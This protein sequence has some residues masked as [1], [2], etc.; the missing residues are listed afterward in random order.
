MWVW[1]GQIL[2]QTRTE[3]LD[4]VLRTYQAAGLFNGT[5]LVQH[6]GEVLLQQGYGYRDLDPYT[7]NLSQTQFQIG[8]LTKQFTA[9]IILRLQEQG[10]LRVSDPL[11]RFLP[12]Y[13]E[14][15]RITLHHL[16]SHTAGVWN[17]TDD[18]DLMQHGLGIPKTRAEMLALFATKP[19]QFEPGSDMRYSNSG[20]LLLGYVIE[21]VTGMSYGAAVRSMVFEPLGMTNSG[22][23]FQG[24]VSDQKAVGY[25][26]LEG[27][28]GTPA[29]PVHASVSGA[30]GALY[31]TASDLLIWHHALARF[32]SPASLRQAFTPYRAGFG[33]GW[34]ADSIAGR[35]GLYHNGSIP[36]FTSNIYRVPEDN[37]CVILL[38]NQATPAIDTITRTLLA[39]LYDRP[40][41]LPQ[42]R[43]ELPLDRM[44]AQACLGTYAFRPD[45]HMQLFFAGKALYAQRLGEAERFELFPASD[46]VY[47][48]KAFEAEL[49]FAGRS[50][51]GYQAL[52]LHQGGKV[53]TA[54]RIAAGGDSLF[55]ILRPYDSLYTTAAGA[56]RA[57]V[58]QPLLSPDFRYYA[59]DT[60]TRQGYVPD[61]ASLEVYLIPG[62]GAITTGVIRG[63]DPSMPPGRPVR[64]IHL[65]Q[66]RAG[67]W[68]LRQVIRYGL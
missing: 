51:G 64:Y 8:S 12:A 37:T 46:S 58:L 35:Q 13:P 4:A 38:A 23:D 54:Q 22:Y 61:P 28:S 52:S 67:A 7:L 20:Y 19:L 17:Y 21:E 57:D 9:A 66:Y 1:S 10:D 14:G 68:T 43:R 29:P 31:A 24:L 18:P 41:V 56:R 40:Y 34:V 65:W 3:V 55:R 60:L 32:L 39:I 50:A 45:F 62:T 16:L 36:G 44:A 48:L 42:R 26:R 63:G 53:F 11:S 59:D 47:F 49:R 15:D 33:Y 5:A 6:R 25:L 30:G 27:A 2:A